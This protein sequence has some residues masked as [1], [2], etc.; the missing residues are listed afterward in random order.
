M[1]SLTLIGAHRAVSA[2]LETRPKSWSVV[3]FK[4]LFDRLNQRNNELSHEMLSLRSTGEVVARAEMGGRQEP[5]EASLPKYLI[6]EIDD[7][8]V[9]PM[10]LIGGGIGVSRRAGAVS[11]DYRVFRSRGVLLP[12]FIHYLLRSQPYLDQYVLYTRAQTTFDR[13][14]QQPD[15]DNLPM[16]VPP[17]EEQ[18]AIANYL[19]RETVRID[20]LIEEQQRLIEM[21][22]ERRAA[23]VD[24]AL[25][26]LSS[27]TRTA[28]KHMLSGIDQGVSPQAEAGL[29]DEPGTWGVLK[30]GCVNRG[31]FRQEEHK[32]LPNDFG[33]DPAIGVEVGD[34]IVS[35]ANGSP[36]LVGSAA[37]VEHL[38]YRLILSDKLF[39][40][41]PKHLVDP[42]FLAWGLNSGRYRVQVRRAISG[43]E[44]L[45]NNLPLSKLRAFE[46]HYPSLTEQRRIAAYLD[47]QTVKIDTL[48]A[49]TWRFIE[50]SK[51]RRTALI[52][53]AVTGQ[54]DVREV[55]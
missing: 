8:I 48:I 24:A 11:P 44:G 34:V 52:A 49:E 5:D 4:G 46:M 40:L 1:S 10:W 28:L 17:L 31:V 51:E 47:G 36:D 30:A 14:V 19:D 38:D 3:R 12:R 7:L 21:L 45:A 15:L 41:R 9:N 23:M 35:R 32:R 42:K 25:A 20:M 26:P 18:R 16:P 22:G 33:F 6:A 37:I 13:R 39:R 43:A 50:I 55:V 53:A 2:L 27:W 54:I 29:A